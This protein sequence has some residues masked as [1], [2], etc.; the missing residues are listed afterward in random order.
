ML[1]NAGK[2]WNGRNEK[3]NAGKF[4]PDVSSKEAVLKE[5]SRIVK[6]RDLKQ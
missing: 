4:F 5:K 6:V 3:L 2:C 1:E